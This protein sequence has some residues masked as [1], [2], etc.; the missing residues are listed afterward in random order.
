MRRLLFVLFLLAC[1]LLGACVIGPKQDD[2]AESAPTSD[3]GLDFDSSFSSDTSG[4]LDVGG[5]PADGAG[6]GGDT[7]SP[8]SG[9]ASADASSDAD[10]A[11]D[12]APDVVSEAGSDAVSEGG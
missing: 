12:A 10:A 2:P 4:G 8:P 3:A 7:T 1:A 6:G 11:S 5:V 9:D